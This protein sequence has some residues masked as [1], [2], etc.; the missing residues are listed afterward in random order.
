[1]TW[2]GNGRPPPLHRLDAARSAKLESLLR[3]QGRQR[4]SRALRTSMDTIEKLRFGGTANP[5]VVARI[6]AALDQLEPKT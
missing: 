2:S 1:M 4:L 5:D 6:A 3:Y